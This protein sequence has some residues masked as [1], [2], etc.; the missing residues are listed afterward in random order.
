MKTK[1]WV[2]EH[3]GVLYGV[4][5]LGLLVTDTWQEGGPTYEGDYDPPPH[6]LTFV[7]RKAARDWCRDENTRTVK[8]LK[9]RPV[10]VRETVTAIE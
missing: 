4:K 1:A 5:G 3:W 9:F 8:G 10:R 6:C 2:R 7:T